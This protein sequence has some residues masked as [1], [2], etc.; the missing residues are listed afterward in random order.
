MS[1]CTNC[2]EK[3]PDEK[4]FCQSCGN[5]FLTTAATAATATA[6]AT[7]DRPI[8]ATD[9]PIAL[10]NDDTAADNDVEANKGMAI[11]AYI[12]FFVPLLTGDS[13]KSEFVRYHTNQG[14]IL[15]VA[16]VALGVAL[17]IIF[18]LLRSILW[19]GYM[20]GAYSLLSTLFN[21]LWLA[22]IALLVLGIINA[23]N[24]TT[25]PLPIIGEKFT[26]IK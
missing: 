8:T 20:W 17:N 16:T 22:P 15:F 9:Q 18:A 3:N 13:K 5:S 1:F 14:A 10:T 23:S 25:K 6:P 7:I 21:T 26:L 24:G 4:K 12:L 19:R 11:F 2:G